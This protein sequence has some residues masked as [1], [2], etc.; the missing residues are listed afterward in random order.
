MSEKLSE[1]ILFFFFFKNWLNNFF[2]HYI[3]LKCFSKT[4]W[5]IDS[6]GSF[7]LYVCIYLFHSCY[8]YIF[9]IVCSIYVFYVS[10]YNFCGQLLSL[11]F[12]CFRSF[13]MFTSVIVFSIFVFCHDFNFF[14]YSA[15]IWFSLIDIWNFSVQIF[16]LLVHSSQARRGVSGISSRLF[17]IYYD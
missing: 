10:F 15:H 17:R 7:F 12:L 2:L 11:I 16:D 1:W 8:I 5:H 13:N 9:F 4:N 3:F 14:Y 6:R